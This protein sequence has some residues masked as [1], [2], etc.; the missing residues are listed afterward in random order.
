MNNDNSDMDIILSSALSLPIL[1]RYTSHGPAA[2][3]SARL[4]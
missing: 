4:L 1:Y 2:D 3:T